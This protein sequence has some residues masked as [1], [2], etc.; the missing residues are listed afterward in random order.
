MDDRVLTGRIPSEACLCAIRDSSR[1]GSR[2]GV[3]TKALASIAT[4]PASAC[5]WLPSA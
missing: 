3:L 5:C 4:D 1:S 2:S